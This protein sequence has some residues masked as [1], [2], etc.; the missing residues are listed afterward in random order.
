MKKHAE[1]VH[2]HNHTE[3]SLLDGACRILDD[4]GD[5]AA[6]LKTMAEYG[7]PA[8]AIT[9]HGNMYGAIEFYNGCLKAGIKPIVGM[10]AYVAS[11]SHA[12][13]QHGEPNYHLTL[14]ARNAAGYRNLVK[15]TSVSF[16][17]GFY[18]KPRIDKELL[19]EYSEGLIAMSGC[20]H[21]ELAALLMDGQ[22]A[23]ARASADFYKQLFGENFYIELME[24]GMP[25]QVK[26]NGLLVRLAKEMGI[27]VVATNDCHY[28]KREDAEAHEILVCVGTASTL[29]DPKHMKFATDQ[30]YYKSPQE[31]TESFRD[32]P[33]AIK[34]TL[35]ISEKCNLEMET[36]KLYLP[37]YG[38]P[39][40]YTLD[41]YLRALCEDGIKKRYGSA[42]AEISAR[43]DHELKIISDMGYPGYFLIVWD[44]IHYAKNNGVPVG[45]G[46]GS[47]AGAIVS[48]LL[49]ITEVDPL[50]YDLLFE[51]FLNPSRKTMPDLD[52]DFSDEG[53]EKV[54]EYV[55]NKYG[56]DR[57]VQIITFGSML[58]KGV[59][60][61][62]G[63]VLSIPL[64]EINKISAMIPKT[65]GI[66]LTQAL[67]Q[68]PELKALYNKSPETKK[69][70]DISLKLEGLK[71]NPGVHAAGIV[72][73]KDDATKYVP[74][75]TGRDDTVTTQYE[76]KL[77][78]KMGLLKMDFL[79]LR[80][81][82]VIRDAVELIKQ[83]HGIELDIG[84]IPI[85][86]KK[87]FKLLSDAKVGGVFQ[88]EKAGMRD[89]LKKL[90]P[91]HIS[92]IIALNALYRPGPIGSGMLEDFVARYHGKVKFKY[93]HPKM[94][95][96]LKETYGI[97]VYQEQVMRIATD[98]VGLSLAE[99]D[100]FRSAMS[101]KNAE[102]IERY[103]GVFL[104]GCRKNGLKKEAAEN[105]FDNIKSFGEYGFNK[106]HAAAYGLLIYRTAYL[107]ANYPLEYFVALLSSE[108]GHSSVS[109]EAENKIVQYLN[110]AR[111]FG[112]EILPPD[113][114]RSYS[115]FTVEE[116]G[117][118]KSGAVRFGL[119]AI[120]NVGEGAVESIV[121]E[122]KQ[123]GD[124]TSIDD[125]VS[126]LD[127]QAVNKRVLESLCKAGALD[128]ILPVK[129]QQPA[130][131][132]FCENLD[133]M[134]AKNARAEKDKNQQMLFDV[135]ATESVAGFD[136]LADALPREKQWHEHQLL[137]FEKEV[138]GFY[139]SGHPLA[140]YASEMKIY[141]K[142]SIADIK[143][144][145]SQSVRVAGII[146][147][148]RK[149]ISKKKE[150]Y[151][152]F[153]LE[154]MEDEID[155]LVFPKLYGELGGDALKMDEMVVISGRLNMD[156]EPPEIIAEEVVPFR[157]ARTR[158]VRKVSITLKTVALEKKMLDELKTFLGKHP[159][160]A[161]VE[162]RIIGHK[163]NTRIATGFEIEPNET[164]ISG[165]E[166]ILGRDVIALE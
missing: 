115:K 60:R 4:R 36:G 14:L 118:A 124:F 57:V 89:L 68:V 149:S 151:A 82:T 28:L 45:P 12:S 111:E 84:N 121:A 19:R 92:D 80:T 160:A 156:A 140:K 138:L 81:L 85:D 9:D 104:E 161:K 63:R 123:N 144:T 141:A 15:L 106:S 66:T 21:G 37:D 48:Y 16:T 87:T 32:L 23:P 109:K 128:R 8:L 59:I 34:N 39:D 127:A 58:A 148:L 70:F 113:I 93:E 56:A 1:F 71:R 165:I 69:L 26:A 159:G 152:R 158:L 78:E 44:F 6:L 130:R 116:T 117:T 125:F 154:D 86:D 30:F 101:K 102:L 147:N 114:N 38:V 142:T 61:D 24:N 143:K 97:I 107:K 95:S 112:I 163:G 120:K 33:E 132:A 164:V 122:R 27:P 10:E 20:L 110:D 90:K 72:I 150:L 157:S 74:L 67:S 79:G 155:V 41:S 65:L 166:R 2:L 88:V 131:D 129:R 76:G 35:E 91:K 40:G 126:R 7:M 105:I 42:T 25:E 119:F 55:R 103:R 73:A 43:L 29:S 94:E 54:I 135:S 17:K 133:D 137:A 13:R 5:P 83:R 11:K 146:A 49:G 153:K 22:D 100:T 162:F 64:T 31:M 108:I 145:P 77:L 3:Y 52:I 50:K 139:L 47:G 96:I 136:T 62:V 75:A 46:R 51:R 99:A 98:I 53:R 134:I 18:Y